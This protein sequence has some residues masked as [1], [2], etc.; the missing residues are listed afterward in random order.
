M[1]PSRGSRGSF[2]VDLRETYSDTLTGPQTPRRPAYEGLP[3]LYYP[4]FRPALQI[5][6]PQLRI[7]GGGLASE[8]RQRTRVLRARQRLAQ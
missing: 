4:A 3:Y 7:H 2:R 5:G 6:R 1:L 8:A